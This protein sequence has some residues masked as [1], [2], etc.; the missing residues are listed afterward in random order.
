M[1]RFALTAACLGGLAGA[2]AA[3]AGASDS[4]EKIFQDD[5]QLLFE[6]VDRREATLDMIDGLGVDVVRVFVYWDAVAPESRSTQRPPRFD[7]AD[8]RA[9]PADLWDRYDGLVR[10]A[11]ARGIAVLL[12]PTS[13]I[14]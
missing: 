6:G 13:P 9:Y 4:Q 7:G 14:P 12:T 2:W 11:Q 10:A 3:P 5:R 8:P 1:R